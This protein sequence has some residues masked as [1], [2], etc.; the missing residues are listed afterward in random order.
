MPQLQVIDLNPKPANPRQE[1]AADKFF[2]SFSDSIEANRQDRDTMKALTDEYKKLDQDG[3]N[4]AS[5]LKDIDTN[6]NYSPTT[7]VNS[8]MQLMK[9]AEINN[10]YKN[11]QAKRIKEENDRLKAQVKSQ[12][13]KKIIRDAEIANE[14]PEG[15][16][17]HYEENL[18]KLPKPAK[19]KNEPIT[20]FERTLQNE[21]AKKLVQLE[22]DLPK[23]Q[24]ALENLKRIDELAENELKGVKGFLKS[25]FNTEAAKE[26]ENLS[27][28]SIEPIIK[29]FNPVGPIPVAKVNIIRQQF[30]AHPSD[31]LTTIK[32]KNAAL[33][34][35][36]EQ[37]VARIQER[38][39][40]IKEHNG[41]VPPEQLKKF[42]QESSELMDVI[43]DQE[44]FNI[45]LK[46]AGKDGMI[47]GLYSKDGRPLNPIPKEKAKEL[48]EQGLITNVPLK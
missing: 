45:K 8:R 33:R 16:Y 19:T 34:R 6:P 44:S 18:G 7:R 46:E 4:I 47:S 22:A 20:P 36:G 48:Y 15:T 39:R 23:A 24:D 17:N 29:L 10:H 31:L 40:L 11:E 43:A 13:A 41:Q 27:F 25:A 28:T 1:T 42:D 14:V 26:M 35:I 32:G 5:V 3:N 30:Q 12:N 9:F 37:G 38:I 21:E 2:S